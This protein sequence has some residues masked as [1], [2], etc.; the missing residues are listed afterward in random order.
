MLGWVTMWRSWIGAC[1]LI[2]GL[3]CPV[4]A[5]VM[6]ELKFPSDVV[7]AF[8]REG[9]ER[10]E[11]TAYA[12]PLEPFVSAG[13]KPVALGHAERDLYNPASVMKLFT[14]GYAFEVLGTGYTFKTQFMAHQ[15]PKNNVLPGNLIVKGYGNPVFLTTDLWDSLPVC[16]PLACN[17]SKAMWCWTAQPCCLQAKWNP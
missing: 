4:Q 10:T 2:V 16:G 15:E 9:I 7:H 8:A 12:L 5:Q 14:T 3:A 11:W 6:P 13:K 1:W 17:A